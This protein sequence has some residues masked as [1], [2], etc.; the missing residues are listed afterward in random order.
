MKKSL[1]DKSVVVVGSI[2]MDSI[3]TAHGQVEN[4]LGGSATYFS[5]AARRFCPVKIVGV[6]GED[7]PENYLKILKNPRTNLEGLVKMPGKTFRWKGS[8]EN[9]NEAITHDTQLNV[10]AQFDPKLPENFRTSKYIFLANIHPALQEKVLSQVK[11][12][13]LI[14]CDTMNHWIRSYKQELINL[15]KKVRIVILNDGEARLLTG[16]NLLVKAAKAISSFGP[17]WVILKKGEHGVLAYDGKEF[18]ILPA[19]PVEN[20]IDPT[21]AGDSFAGGFMGYLAH[22]GKLDR[23]TIQE[24]LVYGTIVA[25]FTIEDFSVNKLSKVTSA[26]IRRRHRDFIKM[27]RVTPPSHINDLK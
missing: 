2:A 1:Q 13:A 9:P 15:Y 3:Q 21:G 7:F 17:E 27:I 4:A 25:S 26:Q 12:P 23:K 20:V 19:Y 24:A 5:M 14:A 16:E 6:V 10:F 18:F 11:A 8:Y 22:C